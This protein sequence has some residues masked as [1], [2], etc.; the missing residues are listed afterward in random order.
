MRRILWVLEKADSSS[1]G[2]YLR[3]E[4]PSPREIAARTA[5]YM[6]L[7]KFLS[8]AP[9]STPPAVNANYVALPEDQSLQAFRPLLAAQNKLDYTIS[10]E[11]TPRVSLLCSL[12]VC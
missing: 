12:R 7:T 1:L 3:L 5:F 4:N 6:S 10:C 8:C 9:P 2:F 11:V